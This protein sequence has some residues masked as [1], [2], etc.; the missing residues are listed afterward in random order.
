MR[1]SIYASIGTFAVTCYKTNP[2]YQTYTDQ[3]KTAE[4]QMALVFEDAQNPNSVKY[5]K[6]IE[7]CRN[8]DTLRVTSLVLFSILWIDDYASDL[9]TADANCKYL[10]PAY[11]KFHERII[12][13]GVFGKWWKIEEN[14]KDYDVNV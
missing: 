13:F 2:D 8:N 10:K 11:S 14:M 12:D 9:A 7:K 1:S 3:L 6:F 4:N 5:L